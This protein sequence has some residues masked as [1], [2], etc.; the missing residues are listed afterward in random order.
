MTAD[1]TVA[2]VFFPPGKLAAPASK[3]QHRLSSPAEEVQTWSFL[4]TPNSRA[5]HTDGQEKKTTVASAQ[6]SGISPSDV[7]GDTV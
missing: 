6:G 4:S 3:Q 2:N 7:I 1:S 5:F